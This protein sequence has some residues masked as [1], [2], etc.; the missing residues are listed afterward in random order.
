MST[1]ILTTEATLAGRT[2]SAGTILV[3]SPY[4]IQRRPDLYPDPD[5]F[6]P[7]RWLP[8]HAATLPRGAFIAF[9][10]GARKCIGDTFGMLEATLVLAAITACWRLDSIPDV[11]TRPRTRGSIRPHP[12]RMRL[13]Y[14]HL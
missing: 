13:R 6:D 4:L 5:R 11:I 2:L 7:D 14:R 10:G 3:Y 1:R 9:G 12:L 8:E